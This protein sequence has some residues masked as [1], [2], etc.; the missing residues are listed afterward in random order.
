MPTSSTS[1]LL[2]IQEI[3]IL[4]RLIFAL[5]NFSINFASF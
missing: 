3:D 5:E 1:I 4:H 2:T